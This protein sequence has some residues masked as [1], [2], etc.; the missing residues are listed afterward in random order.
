[1]D[2]TR[3][4]NWL[5]LAVGIVIQS[6]SY[7][8]YASAFV[9][10]EGG[11]GPVADPRLVVVALLISPLVFSSVGLISRRPG[12][13]RGVVRS[14]GLLVALGLALGLLSPIIGAAAGFGVGIAISLNM[15]DFEGQLRRRLVAVGLAVAY[16]SVMLVLIPPAGVLA[17]ALLPGSMVGIA[18]EY[19]AWREFKSNPQIGP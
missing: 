5:A 14:T 18:D 10:G 17:G 13:L 6:V 8:I 15:P 19:G 7:L 16:M 11:S 2:P 4:R 12:A 1:V 3:R 9:S